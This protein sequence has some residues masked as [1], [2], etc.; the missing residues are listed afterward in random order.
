MA[1]PYDEE[2]I[3]ARAGLLDAL[4]ALGPLRKAVIL[5]GAQAV[6][7]H[8][9]A[10]DA[11]FAV[12]PF[13]LDAD[14]AIDPG[15]IG[16]EP[17][18]TDAMQTAGFTLSD[19]PGVYTRKG[20]CQVDLLVPEAVGGGGRRGARLGIHGNTAARKV[21]GLEGALV[22]HSPSTIE[23]LA[24]GDL[25]SWGIEV[26]GPAALL[27]AKVHKISE[28]TGDP[29]RGLSL[30]KDAFDIYRLIRAVDAQEL[31]AG[32]QRLVDNDI[33]RAVTDQ[34]LSLFRELFGHTR[35]D[36]TEQ[37]VRHVEGLEDPD[38][39]AASSVSLSEE[40]LSTV[41]RS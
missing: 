23:A 38:F 3:I 20:G 14:I 24:P 39:I 4:D 36:G 28:R 30:D 10:V 18:I 31:A 8:T 33:S 25:R 32:V 2:Y 11:D 22:D 6:Y 13:T 37:V 26:A 34:A 5:V 29:T 15:L 12:S 9:Q 27:V 17:K 7:V 21:R 40:F 41:S 35:A 1:T 19:Q 16:S